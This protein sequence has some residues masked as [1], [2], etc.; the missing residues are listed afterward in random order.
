MLGQLNRPTDRYT[1]TQGER[2]TEKQIEIQ[3]YRQIDRPV[4]G[5]AEIQIHRKADG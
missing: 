5:Y 3:T 1:D 2:Q 4:G